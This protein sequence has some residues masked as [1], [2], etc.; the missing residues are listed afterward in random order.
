MRYYINYNTGAGNE[1]VEGT[2]EDAMRVAEE[3][4]A[5]TQKPVTIYNDDHE[6]VANLQWYGVKPEDD[7]VVT[8][9]FGDHGFYGEWWQM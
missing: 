6:E 3:G 4:L 7:D 9:R 8:A 5:Y 2:I 1:V